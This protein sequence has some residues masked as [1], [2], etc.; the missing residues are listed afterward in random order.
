MVSFGFKKVLEVQ[1]TLQND[2][3]T[4]ATKSLASGHQKFQEAEEAKRP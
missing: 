2:K 4:H 3:W 1:L